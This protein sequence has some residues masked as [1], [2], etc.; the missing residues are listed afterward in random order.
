[1]V[2]FSPLAAAAMLLAGT[3]L[4]HAQ[5]ADA[6]AVPAELVGTWSSKSN[7]TFTG[8]GFYDPAK[9][10]FTEPKH[11]GISY[12]FS[13]DGYFEEAYYRAV[14]NPTNPKCPKGVIQW[15]HGSFKKLANGSLTLEPIKVDGRQLYSDPCAY[16]NSVYTRYN[17][18]EL[19]KR[20]EV[21]QDPY[22]KQKRLN[23]FKFDGS[24]MMPLYLAMTPPQMLPT[25]T[26]NP[27]TTS[28]PGA[29]ATGKVKRSQTP[30]GYS[31][32]EKRTAQAD[33]WWWF[34]VCLTATGGTLYFFF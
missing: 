11:T 8:S 17:S 9:D 1:M 13:T 26:L 20:Y 29:K 7:S 27:L 4:V 5:A 34:G 12:S 30:L 25:S 33:W 3:N 16:K 32:L 19:F 31:V 10:E 2:S 28:T 15:Q 22:H 14:A 21:I 18:T 6:A 24:P 23:L